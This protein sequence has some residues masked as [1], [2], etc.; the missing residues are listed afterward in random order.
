MTKSITT[1]CPDC[2]MDVAPVHQCPA[3]RDLTMEEATEL[4]LHIQSVI[5]DGLFP[6]QAVRLP[7]YEALRMRDD[8]INKLL[9]ARDGIGRWLSA[10]LDD[11]KVC[12]EM[13]TDIEE[14]MEAT[15]V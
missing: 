13:K 6:F 4:A 11:P 14:W 3:P 7:I 8:R 2:G 10:A 9:G 15:N 12:A 1:N 5:D